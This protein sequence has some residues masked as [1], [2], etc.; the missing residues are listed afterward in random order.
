MRLSGEGDT[1]LNGG[2]PGHLYLY[3]NVLE[4]AHFSREED[5]L[6][7]ELH[8]NPA[9][10]AL[11]FESEVPTLEGDSVTVKVPA[12]TQSGR[13]FTV[14][15]KGIAHLHEGGRGDLLVRA[16]VVTP[17]DLT[18]EQRD[19]LRQLADSFGT[20]VGNGEKGFLG[21]IKDALS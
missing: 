3:I 21:K 2:Q 10:A 15:G 18:E 1:G 20:P 4:H 16:S 11:G 17:T 9:Q 6:V 5:D 12:G 13:V 19:L 8:M 14:R 7:Y